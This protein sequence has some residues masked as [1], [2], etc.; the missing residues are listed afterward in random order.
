MAGYRFGSQV[1]IG[2]FTS[3]PELMA[4]S[5]P[6]LRIFFGGFFMMSLQFSGQSTFVALGYSKHA[7]FF[8]LLRKAIIV[9]PLTLILPRFMGINGVFYAEPISNYIGGTACFCSYAFNCM[10]SVVKNTAAKNQE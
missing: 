8:S 6:S 5:I 2:L 10:A 3:E 1:F 9:V 4:V 7:V